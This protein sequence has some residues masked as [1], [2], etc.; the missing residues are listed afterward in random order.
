[1]QTFSKNVLYES[2]QICFIYFSEYDHEE[3]YVEF[4]RTKPTFIEKIFFGKVKKLV[5]LPGKLP[6]WVIE[7]VQDFL[8]KLGIKP[9]M[10]LLEISIFSLNNDI[11]RLTKIMN[12][13]VKDIKI[14]SFK[15]I[16]QCLKL[17]ESFQKKILRRIFDQETNLY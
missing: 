10:H 13:L 14:L 17:V 3:D 9:L 11:L 8:I 7:T 4:E 5:N 15:V 6:Q 12:N 1:M 16:F 2:N